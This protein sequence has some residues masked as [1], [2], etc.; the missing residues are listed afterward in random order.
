MGN[1]QI[2]P[3]CQKER[4]QI[5]PVPIRMWQFPSLFS[6]EPHFYLHLLKVE[7][8]VENFLMLRNSSPILAL[9]NDTTFSQT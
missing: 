4:R 7:G 5:C 6:E 2:T 9:S 8:A 1:A 3:I